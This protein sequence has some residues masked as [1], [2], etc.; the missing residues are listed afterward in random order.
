MSISASSPVPLDVIFS[1]LFVLKRCQ[2]DPGQQIP[3]EVNRV[4]ELFQSN[5]DNGLLNYAQKSL[6]EA[7]HKKD[8]SVLVQLS[9]YLTC[10]TGDVE[11]Q[12][13]QGISDHL[14][15]RIN[16]L[17]YDPER[18][19]EF[20]HLDSLA[21]LIRGKNITLEICHEALLVPQGNHLRMFLEQLSPNVRS[22]KLLRSKA[23][24]LAIPIEFPNLL[25]C[26]LSGV[27]LLSEKPVTQEQK[28]LHLINRRALGGE[29]FQTKVLELEKSLEIT[30][31]NVGSLLRLAGQLQL[32]TLKQRADLFLFET[33]QLK[34]HVETRLVIEYEYAMT[35]SQ[36][37]ES[38][39]FFQA[40]AQDGPFEVLVTLDSANELERFFN[41]LTPYKEAINW[42]TINWTHAKRL[43]VAKVIPLLNK[44]ALVRLELRHFTLSGDLFAG[45]NAL[46]EL[47]F[48]DCTGFSGADLAVHKQQLTC[49]HTLQLS[50]FAYLGF[51]DVQEVLEHY[52]LL[53]GLELSGCPKLPGKTVALLSQKAKE[54][55]WLNLAGLNISDSDLELELPYL[56]SLDISSTQITEKA[57]VGLK[58]LGNLRTLTL[59][60]TNGITDVSC[61]SLPV[62]NTLVEIDISACPN[63]TLH[64]VNAIVKGSPG[65]RKLYANA[66]KGMIP[67]LIRSLATHNPENFTLHFD[68]RNE[69]SKETLSILL[70]RYPSIKTVKFSHLHG[71]E[72]LAN[73]LGFLAEL[74]PKE[75]L[76]LV[77]AVFFEDFTVKDVSVSEIVALYF[78]KVKRLSLR[79]PISSQGA[80]Y[81]GTTLR[82]VKELALEHSGNLG[83]NQ[84]PL[85][86]AGLANIYEN[87]TQL[88]RLSVSNLVAIT[89]EG[90]KEV[91]TRC[92]RLVKLRIQKCA[93]IREIFSIRKSLKVKLIT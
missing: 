24:A 93:Q 51:K 79:G 90:I 38:K 37:A 28:L 63:I 14:L 4:R 58:K 72:K 32:H 34:V 3:D 9:S 86:D 89:P 1:N 54:L 43:D 85:T 12:A 82:G 27:S 23:P 25:T 92:S 39:R 13:I 7:L 53:R 35:E 19:T 59:K 73:F 49:L 65:L 36:L 69:F 6:Q 20:F 48:N 44:F 75:R 57:L 31:E 77:D 17:V 91:I 15:I 87:C 46:Q 41:F 70:H 8:K 18:I 67:E 64:G 55:R 88:E 5:I 40:I 83:L 26:D 16:A 68:F 21:S 81:I 10:L 30:L 2:S 74:L 61:L 60:Q 80:M 50:N 11:A 84:A 47:S 76:D 52:P 62:L 71:L 45:L 66:I 56:Q 22:L 33:L 42:L 78:T 29:L